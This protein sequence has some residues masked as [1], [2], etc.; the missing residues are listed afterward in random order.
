MTEVA[1]IEKL[2]ANVWARVLYFDLPPA[3]AQRL[4]EMGLV[5]GTRLRVLRRA[6]FGD[7]IQLEVRHTSLSLRKQTAARIEVQVETP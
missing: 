2:P 1:T 7:P 4:M 3:E 6:P 5:K